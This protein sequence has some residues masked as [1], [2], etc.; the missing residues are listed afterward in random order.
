[1]CVCVLCVCVCM[2]VHVCMRV[3][4]VCVGNCDLWHVAWADQSVASCH[5]FQLCYSCTELC[6]LLVQ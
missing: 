4:C 1:M 3:C 2:Y 6:K 5:I